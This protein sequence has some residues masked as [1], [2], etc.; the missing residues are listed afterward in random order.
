MEGTGGNGE[1]ELGIRERW[2]RVEGTGEMGSRSR[3]RRR[4]RGER[5]GEEEVGESP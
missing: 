2:S 1:W 5:E 3:C 4:S